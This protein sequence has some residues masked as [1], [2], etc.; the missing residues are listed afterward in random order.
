MDIGSWEVNKKLALRSCDLIVE[1]VFIIGNKLNTKNI[2]E[3]KKKPLIKDL[4]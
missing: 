1:F 3:I 2:I 4:E